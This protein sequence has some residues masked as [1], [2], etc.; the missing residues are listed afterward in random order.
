[1]VLIVVLECLE[2]GGLGIKKQEERGRAEVQ[3][4]L[5]VKSVVVLYWNA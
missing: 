3:R 1:M 5:A 4:N 2:L